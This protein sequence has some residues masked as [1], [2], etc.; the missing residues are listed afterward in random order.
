MPLPDNRR[1][2]GPRETY[3]ITSFLT[4]QHNDA[5][6]PSTGIVNDKGLRKDTRR[7]DEVRPIY[8]KA[9]VVQ[10]ANGSAYLETSGTKLTCAVYGPRDYAKR[11][12]FRSS[13]KLTCSLTF[14]PFSKPQRF[15]E[16]RDSLSTEYSNFIA[17]SLMSAVC[18][19]AYPKSQIDVYVN[20]LEDNGN[21]LSYAITAA[22]VALADAGIEMVDLVTS[23]SLVF[24]DDVFCLD[25]DSSEQKHKDVYGKMS[26]A[27][28]PSLNKISCLLQDGAAVVE[29]S[30]ELV[31]TCLE[32]CLRVHDV[33]KECLLKAPN[34]DEES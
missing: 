27:Y 16:I 18:L 24:N 14:A 3:Q 30:I 15:T 25:P 19:D 31:N 6:V 2:N 32:G 9:G 10:S 7:T 26:I 17:D 20:V 34:T 12:Q 29:R 5:D 23:S 33:M 28:L 22:S 1:I 4:P 13:G 11:H 8:L 21:T